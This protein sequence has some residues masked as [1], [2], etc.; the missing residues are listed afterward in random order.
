MQ[1]INNAKAEIA[2]DTFIDPYAEN[3][4]GYTNE[5]LLVALNS[6]EQKLIDLHTAFDFEN[7]TVPEIMEH[8]KDMN[9]VQFTRGGYFYDIDEYS[10]GGYYYSRY[11]S[12][13]AYE[14]GEDDEDGGLCTTTIS[15]AVDMALN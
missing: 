13:Q 1:A 6:V 5:T 15:N 4:D 2:D 10:E 7:A 3:T 9:S 11:T 14:D 8:V 12:E